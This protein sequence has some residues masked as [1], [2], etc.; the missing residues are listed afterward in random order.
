MNNI[1]AKS[2][3]KVGLIGILANLF[4][5]II[6]FTIGLITNSLAM[7]ADAINSAS[8]ILSSLITFIG[9]FISNSP[10]D[11]SHNF[12]HQK[13]EQIF[14]A[15]I[16]LIMIIL[17]SKIIIESVTALINKEYYEFSWWLVIICFITILTKFIL[18]KYVTKINKDVNSNL[19][20]A[21]A[22]D[23]KNDMLL[24]IGTLIGVLGATVNLAWLD[25]IMGILIS[26]WIYY[27]A[28]RIIY[29]NCNILLDKSIDENDK[30]NII[31]IIKKYPE[32]KNIDSIKS[33]PI[34]NEYLIITELSIDGN[35]SVNN[36]HRIIE[37]VK[38]EIMDIDAVYDVTIHINPK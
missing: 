27:I 25:S 15:L 6:K 37:N 5:A 11:K 36:S 23:H 33:K 21:N 9:G 7:I 12:G 4:L 34:G 28:I 32:I 17:A 16:G 20:S 22:Q 3:K 19:I 29:E 35:M 30:K 13:I 1:R 8:D 31:E 38:N 10:S 24:T 18:Y 26:L 14:S 2:I